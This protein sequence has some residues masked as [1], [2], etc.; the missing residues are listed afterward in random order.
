MNLLKRSPR[1]VALDRPPTLPIAAP[2]LTSR[3]TPVIPCPIALNN[4]WLRLGA[5]LAALLIA[6]DP[7]AAVLKRGDR[8]EAVRQLQTKLT[9]KG[10]TVGSIDGDFGNGTEFAVRQY[11]VNQGL[12]ADGI[13]GPST[14]AALGFTTTPRC[15]HATSNPQPG[16]SPT[17]PV[18]GR[19][20][21]VTEG[22]ALNIRDRPNGTIIGFVPRGSIV[23][24]TR[25]SGDWYAIASGGWVA[26]RWLQRVR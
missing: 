8:C 18:A 6:A 10:H 25:A 13:V 16:P 1:L 3:V 26:R 19:Y 20:K 5:G 2:R 24:V 21:V 15:P 11:Q 22:N 14:A 7:A 12:E 17:L 9:Q 4:L 23:T